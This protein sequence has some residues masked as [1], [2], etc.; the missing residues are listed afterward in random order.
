AAKRPHQEHRV[1]SDR[2]R[3]QVLGLRSGPIKNTAFRQI[4]RA[5][6]FWGCFAAQRG[7][8]PL[9]TKAT[10]HR[11][12]PAHYRSLLTTEAC[13]PEKP[14]HHK[15]LLIREVCQTQEFAPLLHSH[16]ASHNK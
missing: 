5:G 2:S 13:S 16:A 15:D 1:S 14:A 7:A 8:S 9:T 3:R 11:K 12:K 10:A 6:R 4:D